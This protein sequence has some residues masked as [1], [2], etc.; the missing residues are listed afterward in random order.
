MAG[1][2]GEWRGGPSK[3]GASDGE[4]RGG[5][6]HDHQMA[7]AGGQ[8][9]VA[10]LRCGIHGHQYSPPVRERLTLV[11]M[12]ATPDEHG[13][14]TADDVAAWVQEELGLDPQA[15]V[16]LSERPGTDPRCSPVVTEV[17]ITSPG[18]ERYS[19]HIERPL[20]EVTRMDVV[21]ALAF[22][23]GH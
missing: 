7:E 1:R 16:E 20:A 15:R 2:E 5:P 23:G 17:A 3:R 13:G 19:F 10:R 18:E 4:G 14:P 11:E 22:G 6:G 12:A 8:T 21:A 9:T